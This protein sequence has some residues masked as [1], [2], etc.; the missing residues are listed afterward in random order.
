VYYLDNIYT[1]FSENEWARLTAEE[2]A[3][4]KLSLKVSLYD[5]LEIQ[6]KDIFAD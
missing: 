5:D 4:Q 6:L 2:R 1:N 3:E